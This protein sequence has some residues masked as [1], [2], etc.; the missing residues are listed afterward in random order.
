MEGTLIDN[1]NQLLRKDKFYNTEEQRKTA[2]YKY[3]CVV[4]PRV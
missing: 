2:E 3:C 4:N 1:G